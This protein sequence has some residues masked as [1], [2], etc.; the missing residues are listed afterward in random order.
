MLLQTPDFVVLAKPPGMETVSE[1]GGPEL[2]A[3][4]RTLLNDPGLLPVH[5]LDR[6][7][8]GAQVLARNQAAEAELAKLFRQRKVE[9]T[10]LA[11][12]LGVPRNR[13]GAIN[14]N[15]SEWGGGR[16][17]VRVVKQGG[18]EASTHY[19]VLGASNPL[20]DGWK[21]G[22][23]AF[24]PHQGRTHQIRVH[25][26]SLGYP[27]LG[28]DQYGDRAANQRVKQLFGLK[29]QAL[30]AWRVA[31]EWRGKR[32]EAVCPAPEDMA[33]MMEGLGLKV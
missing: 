14:R 15:L 6:D 5:R 4:A 3:T 27:I 16:R 11:L 29:R 31:F 30:H 26:A 28:D 7:T 8:S 18:L 20:P 24:S 12:C 19:E 2:L 23:L 17:P 13:N 1:D 10:Y 32:V 25:A 9:K 21:V 33:G 22:L